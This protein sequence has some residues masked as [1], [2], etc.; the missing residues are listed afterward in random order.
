MDSRRYEHTASRSPV[1]TKFGVYDAP[2]LP[3]T[4]DEH[5]DRSAVGSTARG[6]SDSAR[7]VDGAAVRER[8]TE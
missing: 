6:R 3:E 1:T 7:R 2:E 4:D 5:R 8:A